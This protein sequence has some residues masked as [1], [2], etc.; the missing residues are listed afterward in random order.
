MSSKPA[1]SPEIVRSQEDAFLQHY[2]WLLRWALQFTN[3]DRAR[4]EDL[5]QEV[6]AQFAFAHTD[7]SA[8]QNVPA[9]LYTSLRN[10]HLSEVRRAGRS[11]VQSLSIIEYS[12]AD[13]ALEATD[14][15]T[16]YQTQEQLQRICQYAC[17]RKQSSR[18]GSVLILRFF[19]GYHLS[20]VG[21]VLG[22]T[23]QAVRQS[24]RLARNE[25]RLFL[26]NPHALK[27]ID[28]A[29]VGNIISPGKVLATEE[30]LATLRLAIFSSCQG[31]CLATDELHTLY[32]KNLISD[33]D[34]SSLAH[35]VSCPQ[36]LDCANRLLGLPLLTERHPSDAFGPN[37]NSS[38]GGP[39]T[40][41]NASGTG[42]D[43]SSRRSNRF[44]KKESSSA[45]MLRCRRRAREL[46]EHYPRELSVTANGHVLGSQSVNAEVSRLRLDITIDETLSF[47]EVISEENARL[48]VMVVDAPPDGEPTQTSRVTLSEG[49]SIDAT[50]RYGH[51]WPMLEVIYHDPN[52]LAESQLSIPVDGRWG[53]EPEEVSLAK[54]VEVEPNRRFAPIDFRRGLDLIRKPFWLRPGFI[55]AALSVFLICALLFLRL[56]ITPTVT[57]ASLLERA[58]AVEQS[59]AKEKDQATHRIITLEERKHAGSELIKRS[60]IEIWRDAGREITARRVYD[61]KGHLI[62]GEWTK[63]S[64]ENEKDEST[65]L[66]RTIYHRDQRPRLEVSARNSQAIIRGLEVWQL[67][68]S[69]RD[70]AQ[71]I[72]RADAAQVSESP[73]V[74]VIRYGA[75]QPGGDTS[76]LGATLTL[77]KSDLHPVEQTLIVRRTSETLEYRFVEASF[78]QTSAST[79]A[80]TVFDVD[81]E[82]V[83]E[84]AKAADARTKVEGDS[85]HLLLSNTHPL[86]I[87]S[88]E[89]ELEVAYILNPFRA[90]FGDQVNLRRTGE[91]GLLVEGVVDTEQ[92]KQEILRA[93]ASV[94]NNPAVKVQVSTAAE[95]LQRKRGESSASVIVHEFG[96]SNNTI[97]VYDELHRYFSHGHATTSG[98]L[99]DDQTVIHEF[100][101]RI[102][103]RSRRTLSHAIELKRLAERFSP[104]QLRALTP[105]AR[106]KWLVMLRDHSGALHRE[107]SLLQRELQPV[108]FP[109]ETLR[110]QTEGISITN[111]DGLV[112]AIGRLYRLVLANDEAVRTAFTASSNASKDLAVKAP[113]FWSSLAVVSELSNRVRRSAADSSRM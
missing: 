41:G 35:L 78:Q 4:A 20:E 48:L 106:A 84:E 23:Y 10:T 91:G 26:D 37:N 81:P 38:R 77:R 73:E 49:R 59:L 93:L 30:L 34:N 101:A 29:Q 72:G 15:H 109:T 112:L 108:F 110:T 3:N 104:E 111:D 83:S 25:A 82:L 88:P 96:V 95:V 51:P 63:R 100:A 1:P 64:N 32:E 33:A 27:F 44:S 90:R 102:V 58:N 105:E 19:Y 92:T 69:P 56:N 71:M 70:F 52:F 14:P 54:P 97:P 107:T 9:Y 43:N 80:P 5:V 22:G 60:R 7:L 6:F 16:L 13:F 21:E 79:V 17:V 85:P 68:P 67:E 57:A 8:V 87:A 62:A 11:H 74:Y 53:P 36:C 24:L 94:S 42:A 12:V 98:P 113:Q 55:T 86:A 99:K 28:R 75:Q 103:S 47:I 46:F 45:F 89:L 2:K 40:T 18:A 50:L 39:G 31:E 61:E 66:L 65:A 76:L